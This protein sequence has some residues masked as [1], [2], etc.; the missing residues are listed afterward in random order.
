MCTLPTA[1]YQFNKIPIEISMAFMLP[2]FKIHYEEIVIKKTWYWHKNRH[3]D[4]WNRI[5]SPEINPQTY[6]Q[7]TNNKGDKNI[8]LWKTVLSINNA[9]K[10]NSVLFLH[11]IKK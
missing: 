9:K 2:D 11:H 7:L 3:I 4:Q 8:T 5:E 6:G 10:S 1:V